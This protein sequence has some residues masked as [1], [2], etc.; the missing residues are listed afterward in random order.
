MADYHNTTHVRVSPAALFD[1]LSQIEN[2]PDYFARMRSAV[3]V[4]GGDAVQ[5]S[6]ELP[7]GEVVEGEAWFRVDHAALTMQWAS[8]GP[9][10]YHGELSVASVDGG[11]D[12]GARVHVVVS[13]DRVESEQVQAGVDRTVATIKEKLEARHTDSAP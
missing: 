10:D 1:Y 5:T 9:R 13:T 3:P 2:L 11:I 12:A 6:A 7:N 4:A 8:E